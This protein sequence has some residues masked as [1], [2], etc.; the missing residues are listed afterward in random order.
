MQDDRQLPRDGD[1]GLLEA[2]PFPQPDP[3]RLSS[4]IA[5]GLGSVIISNSI[6]S[7]TT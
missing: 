2:D 7:Q 6:R 3:P 4:A 5:V 1:L